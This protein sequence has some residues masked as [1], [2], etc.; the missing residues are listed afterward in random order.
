MIQLSKLDKAN[1]NKLARLYD[2]WH[3]VN[4]SKQREGKVS[5]HRDQEILLKYGFEYGMSRDSMFGLDNEGNTWQI[6]AI[7]R[8]TSPS[9]TKG[10]LMVTTWYKV[11][12]RGLRHKQLPSL[13]WEKFHMTFKRK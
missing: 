13:T 12:E 1:I 2:L 3:A 9:G 11:D 10:E 8:D 5:F 6:T 4:R 7:P